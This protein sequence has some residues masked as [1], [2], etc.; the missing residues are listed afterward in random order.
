MTDDDIAKA[1]AAIRERRQLYRGHSA[2]ALLSEGWSAALDEVERLAP[3]AAIVD[4][5]YP[6]L[7][8]ACEERERLRGLLSKACDKLS[9]AGNGGDADDLRNSGGAE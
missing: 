3:K 5:M 2:V 4:D 8:H 6:T 1:R 9:A 7:R